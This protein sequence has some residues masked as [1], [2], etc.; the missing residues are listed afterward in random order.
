[1]FSDSILLARI[2]RNFLSNAFRYTNKGKV[3]LGCRR[4]GN[5]ICIEVWDN[6][7]GIEQDQQAEIFKE[8]K[9]LKSSQSAF[10]NG[11]GLGL[12][13]VDKISKVL[14]HPIKVSSTL[15]KGS[16][17][18]VSVPLADTQKLLKINENITPILTKTE[19]AERTIWLI[20]NDINICI[21][22]SKLLEAWGCSVI[23]ARRYP[24]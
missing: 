12:A 20:D 18:S 5:N 24:E 23:S 14:K 13:I 16:L 21:A 15:G 22:M 10:S 17:F 19:L 9:R 1:V 8:F 4:S 7:A 11:L 3:L 2:L 6:G